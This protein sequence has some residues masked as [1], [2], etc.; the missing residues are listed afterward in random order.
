MAVAGSIKRLITC[1]AAFAVLERRQQRPQPTGLQ[2]RGAVPAVLPHHQRN[3]LALLH[4][5]K[6]ATNSKKTTQKRTATSGT[7]IDGTSSGGGGGGFGAASSSNAKKGYDTNK[8]TEDDYAIFPRLE[9]Q[10]LDTLVPAY[11]QG[12]TAPASSS[13]NRN[14][15]GDLPSEIY[16][17]LSQIYG[18]PHFNYQTVSSA[19]QPLTPF[20]NEQTLFTDLLSSSLSS[21]SSSPVDNLF[22]TSSSAADQMTTV[23]SSSFVLQDNDSP[24][25]FSHSLDSLPPF[26]NFRV[27]H[28]DPLVLQIDQ[29]FTDAECDRY[30]ALSK[31]GGTGKE[32]QT[33]ILSSRS[34]TVGKD[35]KSKA[36][37]TSTTWYHYYK[38]VPELMAKAC[39]LLGLDT[40]AQF[41][42]PQTVRYRRNEKFTWHLDALGPLENQNQK[43][44]QRI[45]TLLVYLTELTET[46]GGATMFR[47][48]TPA[49]GGNTAGTSNQ[50]QLKMRPQKGSA[51]LFF[52]AAGG[53]PD[54]PLDIRTLHCGQAVSKNAAQDKWICQLWLRALPYAPSLPGNVQDGPNIQAAIQEYCQKFAEE[55]S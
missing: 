31:S 48:L 24:N 49:G 36:Q 50:G 42:E 46:D 39:R 55:V 53:I 34:P 45:A 43:G 14:V 26:S 13:T 12:G 1:K 37:R 19:S 38:S 3:S 18:F 32:D 27:L 29:F 15:G 16:Q 44:G 4:A 22:A 10:V 17:R 5:K 54:T 51:L 33:A 25:D 9:Q 30:I 21:S 28:V 7:D 23:P 40:L 52:P 35:A 11:S 8:N 47:D 20:Q 6:A 41:E 2:G